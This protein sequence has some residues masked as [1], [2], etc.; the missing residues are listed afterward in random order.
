MPHQEDFEVERYMDDHENIVEYNIAETCC[1]S[2]SLNEVAEISGNKF[3]FD[4]NMKFVYGAIKG[5]DRLRSLIAKMYSE[6]GISLDKDNVL[7]TNGAIG[8]NFLVAYALAGPGDHIISVA[9]TYQ[10]LFSVPKMFGA[11]VSLLQLKEE[12]GF[13]PNLNDLKGLIRPNTKY[14]I[15]NNPNNPLGSV[16]E[17]S[18]LKKI[19]D[20]ARLHDIHILCDEVYRPL[21]H[22]CET[23]FSITS[24][25]GKGIS[26]CS[27]SK[28]FSMAGT[29][30]GWIV[31]QDKSLL[32]ACASRRDY[33]TISISVIDDYIA[34][35]VLSNKDAILKHNIELCR[36]NLEFLTNWIDDNKDIVEFYNVPRGGSVC[37]VKLKNIPNCYDFS[38][39]LAKTCKVLV[40]P[41][42][43]FGVPGTIRI[44]Y[45]NARKDLEAA[46][47]ILSKAI[48][49]WQNLNRS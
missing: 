3:E 5:S 34:T 11:E 28:A 9:P 4:Y 30:L 26:T 31:S 15:I 18:L 16:I 32:S 14:I 20:I 19:V 39:W 23:P 8:A 12:D 46:L 33:N 49:K 29:R 44:G 1:S 40:V 22:S 13:T 25:Y 27:M 48:K 6:D 7:I 10:Q 45:G 36:G 47:P 41:G 35:Y 38:S 37:L 24:I 17:N 42:I 21:F 2:L 43:T